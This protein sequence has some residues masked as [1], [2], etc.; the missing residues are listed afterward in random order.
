MGKHYRRLNRLFGIITLVQ[1]RRTLKSEDLAAMCEAQ[2]RT[3]L[4]ET[5]AFTR[6]DGTPLT[7][8]LVNMKDW[9]NAT[10]EVSNQLRI[11]ADDSRRPRSI[12]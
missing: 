12:C 6:D 7:Y 2:V 4:C 10:F 1:G 5:N 3:I 11:K 8:A 9:C